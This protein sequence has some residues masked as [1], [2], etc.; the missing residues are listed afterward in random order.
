MKLQQLATTEDI[1]ILMS[2]YVYLADHRDWQGLSELFTE[3]GVFQPHKPDGSVWLTMTGRA[4]IA[5]TLTASSGPRDVLIHHLFSYEVD[6]ASV[7][8]AHGVFAMEDLVFRPEDE[9]PPADFPFRS[10]HGY[11]H[12]RGDFVNTL[13][14]WR[15]ARLVQTR[16]RLD[17]TY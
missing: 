12:Y 16:L 10:M 1:R 15:I 5:E 3:D 7:D 6:V 14:G 2:R 4:Q 13:A 9:E 11:G 17:F 8:D